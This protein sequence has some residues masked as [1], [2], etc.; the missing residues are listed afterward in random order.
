L[1]R[2]Q[3]LLSAA[4]LVLGNAFAPKDAGAQSLSATEA[5]SIAKDATIYGVPMLENYRIMYSYFVNRDDDEEKAVT[6]IEEP[7]PVCK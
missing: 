4:A 5:R 1:N 6:R 7:Q 2:R 3:T